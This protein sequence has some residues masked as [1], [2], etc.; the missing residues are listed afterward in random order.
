MKTN[1]RQHGGK[2]DTLREGFGLLFHLREVSSIL[3]FNV[4]P[5]TDTITACGLIF[6]CRF[7]SALQ[8]DTSKGYHHRLYVGLSIMSLLSICL[9][10]LAYLLIS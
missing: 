5:K 4:V 7:Q 6:S 3:L 1:L 9:I 10:S 2:I 8:S